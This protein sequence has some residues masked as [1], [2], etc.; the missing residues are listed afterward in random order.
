MNACQMMKITYRWLLLLYKCLKGGEI[1]YLTL[2]I[3]RDCNWGIFVLNKTYIP[4]ILS[5]SMKTNKHKN[6]IES[7]QISDNV[8]YQCPC[9]N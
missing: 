9:R 4:T 5:L 8:S 7:Q 1:V 3:G 2:G 6:Y